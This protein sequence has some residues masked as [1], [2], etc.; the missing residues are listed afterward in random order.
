[1]G[2]GDGYFSA[3]VE[4]DGRFDVGRGE[5][6]EGAEGGEGERELVFEGVE[7]ELPEY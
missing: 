6:E 5:A 4:D 2:E 7:L 1:M 3:G